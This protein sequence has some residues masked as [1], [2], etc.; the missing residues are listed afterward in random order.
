MGK[1]CQQ[2]NVPTT[3]N[4]NLS[5]DEYVDCACVTM[6]SLTGEVET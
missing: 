6:T 5:C 1:P 3:N 2:I 4:T